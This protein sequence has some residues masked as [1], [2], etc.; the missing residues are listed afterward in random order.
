[1][2]RNSLYSLNKFKHFL[3]VPYIPILNSTLIS[4]RSHTILSFNFESILK[5]Y[6]LNC[7]SFLFFLLQQTLCWLIPMPNR[8]AHLTT[9][10]NQLQ[11]MYYQNVKI[12]VCNQAATASTLNAIT[13]QRYIATEVN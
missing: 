5:L 13:I 1:M 12:I 7:F 9:H 6:K 3:L 4:T 8:F 2:R 10:Q 11:S